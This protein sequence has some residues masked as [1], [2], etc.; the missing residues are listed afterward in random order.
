MSL[1]EGTGGFGPHG[2]ATR[3]LPNW[4]LAKHSGDPLNRS[5]DSV[6]KAEDLNNGD[7]LG[8]ESQ[9]KRKPKNLVLHTENDMS[10]NKQGS[11]A[12]G[13][14]N[15]GKRKMSIPNAGSDVGIQ[16]NVTEGKKSWRDI[17]GVRKSAPRGR[18]R[19]RR[20]FIPVLEDNDMSVITGAVGGDDDDDEVDLTVED[21]IS[22]AYECVS[23]NGDTEEQSLAHIASK[24]AVLT[25]EPR[26]VPVNPVDTI[27]DELKLPT[28]MSENSRET[29]LEEEIVVPIEKTGDSAQDMLNLLLGPLLNK[30]K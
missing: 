13:K 7:G 6:K 5:E 19:A 20:E 12:E 14:R 24:D 2:G 17:K 10:K 22:I 15:R 11:T 21:L 1:P 8:S 23:A 27:A 16:E 28:F 4:M 3:R 29:V 9:C 30:C 18:K 26:S 25:A